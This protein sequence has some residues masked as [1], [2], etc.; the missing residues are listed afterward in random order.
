[1]LE[2]DFAFADAQGQSRVGHRKLVAS[3]TIKAGRIYT[4]G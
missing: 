3:A 4:G 1:M 2:G